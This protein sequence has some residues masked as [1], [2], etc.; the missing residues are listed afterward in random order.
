MSNVLVREALLD[1]SETLE[2]LET[3]YG[4]GAKRHRRYPNL[5]LLKYD[6]ILSP[7]EKPLVQ[8]CRGIIL[9]EANSWNI[10][11]RPFDKFFNAGEPLAGPVDWGTATVQEKLDGSLVQLYHYDGAWH[12]ATSGTPDAGGPVGDTGKTFCQLIW[13][14]WQ[15][16]S[17]QEPGFRDF[18][19]LFELMTPLNRVVVP[20][21]RNRLVLIGVRDRVTGQEYNVQDWSN[22]EGYEK[23]KVFALKNMEELRAAFE[24]MSG[25]DQEGFVVQDRAFNRVKVKHPRYVLFHQMVGSLTSKKVLDAVRRNETPEI[26]A[27]F[28]TWE[29]EFQR[30]QERYRELVKAYED[31]YVVVKDIPVQKDFAA[32]VKVLP[33]ASGPFFAVRAG[34]AKNFSDYFSTLRLEALAD[35]VGL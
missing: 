19:F 22:V 33:Y 4:V 25:L 26:L 35:M 6:Q 3:R 18:T 31:A 34:K 27:Y 1:G 11:S 8:Q 14:V 28:P 7:M 29:Q 30:V 17:Y 20:H 2:T 10:V 32:A 21:D 13:D 5:V 23:V 9:D 16:K 15:E 24:G 12:F